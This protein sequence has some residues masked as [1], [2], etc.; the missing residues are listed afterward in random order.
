MGCCCLDRKGGKGSDEMEREREGRTSDRAVGALGGVFFLF[1][2]GVWT[3]AFRSSKPVLDG[4]Y[5][6]HISILM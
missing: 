6:Y 2:R 5:E 4:F 1:L 3:K